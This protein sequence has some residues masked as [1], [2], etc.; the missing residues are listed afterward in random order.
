MENSWDSFFEEETRKDYYQELRKFLIH[1]YNT[2][3][4]YPPMDKIFSIFKE[5][6]MEKIEV[7]IL[8]QDPYH[9]PARPMGCPFQSFRG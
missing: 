3:Q 2:K 1:E 9:Q 6:P 7:V 5:V 8:G 4:I